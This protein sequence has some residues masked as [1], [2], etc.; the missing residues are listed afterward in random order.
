M[1]Q[2]KS[3][4][5][6]LAMAAASGVK[7]QV[8][9]SDPQG[10]R[11]VPTNWWESAAAIVRV[12]INSG[13]E[14]RQGKRPQFPIDP[15]KAAPILNDYKARGISAIEIFAPYHGS[16]SYG[17]LDAIDRF[18]VNPEVGTMEDFK[19][20]VRLIHS[21][22][23]AAISFDNLGYCS[24]EVPE[25]LK[26]ADDVRAGRDTAE[27]RRFLWADQADAPPPEPDDDKFFYGSAATPPWQRRSRQE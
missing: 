17:G 20:L 16:R 18:N 25:F 27:A 15:A 11:L 22:G 9:E 23:M 3:L 24:T 6:V 14:G 5:L 1:S 19:A 13:T 7:A 10:R 21:K 8:S 2:S 4:L 12:T 26:A